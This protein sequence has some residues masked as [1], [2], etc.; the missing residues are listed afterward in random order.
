MCLDSFFCYLCINCFCS[1]FFR[2][3]T[4]GPK[5]EFLQQHERY[6]KRETVDPKGDFLQR[7]EQYSKRFEQIRFDVKLK[8]GEKKPWKDLQKNIQVLYVKSDN[9]LELISNMTGVRTL[10]LKWSHLGL[11]TN[12]L[13]KEYH[14]W[15]AGNDICE[16]MLRS[17]FYWTKH[18]TCITDET[19]V[20]PARSIQAEFLH[21][22]AMIHVEGRNFPKHIGL[23]DYVTFILII[24]DAVI[25]D[26]G[27]VISGNLKFQVEA[28][29]EYEA[30]IVPDLY[31]ETLIYDEVI[32]IA[33]LWPDNAYHVT[34]DGIQRLIPYVQILKKY[35]QIRIHVAKKTSFIVKMLEAVGI[36]GDRLITGVIRAK[37]AYTPEFSYVWYLHVPNIQLLSYTYRQLIHKDG[38]QERRSLVHIM[39]TYFRNFVEKAKIT[40]MVQDMAK[41]YGLKYELFL[42][43]KLPSIKDTVKLFDRAVLVFAP[44]GAGLFNMVF[45][46]PGTFILEVLCPDHVTVSYVRMAHSLGHRYYAFSSKNSW[47]KGNRCDEGIKLDLSEL[48]K[49]LRFYVSTSLFLIN[50]P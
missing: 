29:C 22:Q 1:F 39:R 49:V 44:H 21:P 13:V 35:P 4:V 33:H 38:Q 11:S 5:G 25:T 8:R 47:E 2:F 37:I 12:L 48:T 23:P 24:Q 31:N 14:D 15:A 34:I 17:G 20:I 9:S 26:N 40:K 10:F 45:S 18:Q 30:K 32:S 36:S 16:V 6:Y 46:R 42:D 19:S 7:Y 27:Y 43:T 50:Q 41:E 3:K 28:E